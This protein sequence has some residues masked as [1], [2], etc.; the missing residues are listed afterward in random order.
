MF[1]YRAYNEKKEPGI[2][3][4]LAFENRCARVRAKDVG[5]RSSEER[6]WCSIDKII[7]PDVWKVKDRQEKR[8]KIVVMVISDFQVVKKEREIVTKVTSNL[9]F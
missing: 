6:E 8:Y 2:R 9:Y 5:A 7:Y 1:C 3:Q 4:A